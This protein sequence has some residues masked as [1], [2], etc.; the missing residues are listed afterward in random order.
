M[1]AVRSR[2]VWTCFRYVLPLLLISLTDTPWAAETVFDATDAQSASSHSWWVTPLLL[3]L[4][5]VVLGVAAVLGGIGGGVL[6]VPLVAGF[7]SFHL[8]FV[9]GAGLCMALACA[10]TASP[11]LL[12]SGMVN[13]R[14]AMPLGLLASASAIIGAKIGL[15]MPVAATQTALGITILAVAV[16]MLC[17]KKSEVPE[18]IKPDSLSLAL[19]MHGIFRDGATGKDVQWHVHRT[20]QGMLMFVGIGLLAGMFGLGAGWANVPVLNLLMGAPLKVAVATSSF[21]LSIVDTSAV[22]VY[23]NHGAILALMAVPSILGIML[24][25][26]LGVRLLKVTNAKVIR[27]IVIALLL[28][29]GSRSLLK[30]LG[31]WN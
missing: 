9:R 22:W 2:Y 7:T 26:L 6:F 13:L 21:I 31:I 23:V 28:I 20:P 3:F 14:L 4:F 25:S 11:D 30:G 1:M 10:V 16:I 24:G 5:T 18:N 12:R 17:A 8:D 19:Q 15:A 29:A 27:H